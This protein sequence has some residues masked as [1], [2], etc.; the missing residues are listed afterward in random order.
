M[1]IQILLQ[2]IANYSQNACKVCTINARNKDYYSYS[3]N[4][5]ASAQ[6]IFN[7]F[8]ICHTPNLVTP[9]NASKQIRNDLKLKLRHVR[10]K[11]TFTSNLLHIFPI[12][13]LLFP[14]FDIRFCVHFLIIG[15]W[16]KNLSLFLFLASAN[17][18]YSSAR[19]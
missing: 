7:F 19:A 2:W 10:R 12:L 18:F 15:Y 1:Q 6:L 4:K 9:R 8:N 13:I 3:G 17:S 16:I 5:L 11:R 14:Y